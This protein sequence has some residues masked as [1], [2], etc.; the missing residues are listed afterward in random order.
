MA[1]LLTIEAV[2]SELRGREHGREFWERVE[3]D[4]E[5]LLE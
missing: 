4:V 5:A 3:S 2:K 1:D